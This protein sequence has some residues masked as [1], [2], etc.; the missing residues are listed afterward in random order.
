MNAG[1][2]PSAARD[3]V[4]P[5]NDTS[6]AAS[7]RS[8]DESVSNGIS[9]WLSRLEWAAV[10]LVGCL[11]LALHLRFVTNVGGLWRDEANSANLATLP[12]FA[13]VWRFLDYDSFPILFFAVLRGWLG[14]FG[15]DN[16]VALRALGFAIGIGVLAALWLNARAFGSRL[17][18]LSLALVGLNPMVIR[19]GDSNRAYG[20]G[21]TLILLT[22]WSFWRLVDSPSRPS[23]K[24]IAVS[25]L[26]ALLSV[27]C[28]YYNAVLLLAIAAG[29]ITVAAT[30]RA[31]RTII[32]VLSI[33]LVS[34]ISLLPYVP[35]M[36][37]MREWAF[38][39]SYPADWDWLWKRVGEVIG[40][41][42]P[43]A[44]WVWTGLFV[45]AIG[46]AVAAVVVSVRS[47][48]AGIDTPITTPRFPSAVAFAVVTL[49][50]GVAGYGAFLNV[51]NYYTQP[52][53]YITIAAF[54]ACAL[55]IVFGASPSG[56]LSSL[57][58]LI[59][60]G[61]RLGVA[62]LLI[63]LAALPAWEELPTRHTNL[64]LVAARLRPLAQEGDVVLVP[65]WECAI[66]LCRYY[67]GPASVVTLPPIE[68]HRFH[69]YDLVL[70][71]LLTPDSVQPVLRQIESAL[72]SG[73][74]VFIVGG[75][76]FPPPDLVAPRLQ[77]FYRDPDGGWHGAPPYANWHF[78]AGQFL[79]M[80]T[81]RIG[82]VDL[83]LPYG[84]RLQPFEDLDLTVASGWQ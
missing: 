80:H 20:L 77:P 12:A 7:H 8:A 40:S 25:A 19:Y 57:F 53:Y 44:T 56:P 61:I 5:S 65:R 84:T 27:Q 30:R 54:A 43:I 41:P 81:G 34:A 48:Q 26:L 9:R 31:W 35:M 24:R 39:V 13:D 64:D 1:I 69:R 16:D 50:V 21:I 38:L 60:R 52:W 75:L 76:P 28:L 62:L 79:R 15:T 17:P 82:K 37:R 23:A 72:R 66:P 73:H 47:R 33:G 45:I 36:R 3:V 71:E 18:V 4:T 83:N 70:R 49:V 55:D 68:D 29:A 42:D 46:I 74:R 11:A 2:A 51:L 22:L 10:V 67:R 63:A 59:L 6:A 78:E 14:I 58:A 32:I